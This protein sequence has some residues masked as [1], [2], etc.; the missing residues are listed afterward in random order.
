M[1]N[2]S[3][4]KEKPDG[5]TFVIRGKYL[6]IFV[7]IVYVILFFYS[8]PLALASLQKS[9]TVLAEILPIFAFVILFTAIINYLLR[10]QKIVKYLG[11]ESGI[12]GWFW[13]LL[14]GVISHGPVYAWF[15]MLEDLRKHGMR[16]ALLVVF[17]YARA[18][19]LPLLPI[20]IDYFG[21]RFT[22][23][24]SVY[25]LVGSIIQG[26]LL[27]AMERNRAV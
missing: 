20:M 12:R 18:I 7:L 17:I 24:L 14:G 16:D 26:K 22:L 4:K 25:I 1:N 23:L 8:T 15:P 27:E 19:K 9:A 11:K 5:N 21:W 13:S 2:T 6:F 10:P 3:T